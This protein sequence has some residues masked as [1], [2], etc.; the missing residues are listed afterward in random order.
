MDAFGCSKS[1]RLVCQ[2]HECT[3]WSVLISMRNKKMS[4]YSHVV[5]INNPR[6][7]SIFVDRRADVI[8]IF[9]EMIAAERLE[10]ARESE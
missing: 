7:F 5:S 2:R 8:S 4:I 3:S 1:L 10:K 9:W 6:L